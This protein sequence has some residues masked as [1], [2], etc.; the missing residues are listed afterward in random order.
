MRRGW[1]LGHSAARWVERGSLTI[2][3]KPIDFRPEP[4]FIPSPE[5]SRLAEGKARIPQ[6][7]VSRENRSPCCAH[8]SYVLSNVKYAP[9]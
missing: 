3:G 8:G 9:G 4:I 6:N 1:G 5:S 2:H 7:K